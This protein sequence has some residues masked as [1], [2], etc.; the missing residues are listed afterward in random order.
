M[1]RGG[2]SFFCWG[3]PQPSLAASA[4]VVIMSQAALAQ[5]NPLSSASTSSAWNGFYVGANAGGT[6]PLNVGE[7]L[8]SVYAIRPAADLYPASRERP[9]VSFGIQ[10]GYNW[11][12]GDFVYGVETDINFLDGRGGK[13]QVELQPLQYNGRTAY[14][15]ELKYQTPATFFASLRGRMGVVLGDSLL[16]LTGGVA[17][18]GVRGPASLTIINPDRTHLLR[19]N[20]S[21]SKQI[22]YAFGLGLELPVSTDATAKI[23]T[24][25][26]SQ[27]YNNQTF[28]GEKRGSFSSRIL[29][30]NIVAR[31]GV[32]HQF[33][34]ANVIDRLGTKAN[35]EADGSEEMFS[36][37]GVTTTVVQG[38]PHFAAAYS[39]KNSFNPKGEIRSG[40]ISDLFLGVRLWDGAEAY[41]N[42][43]LIQGYG[44]QNTV[45]TA[46]YVNAL[47]TRVGSASPYL[48]M[49][50]YF[51]RQTIGLGG[52]EQKGLAETGAASEMLEST[53]DQ[54]ARRVDRD[55]LTL[56]VGKYSVQDIF[57]DNI[58][59]HDP[60][61]DFLN[62]A[63]TTLGA[64]DYAADAWGYS[65]GVTA[66]LKKDWWTLRSGIFQLSQ[67]PGRY[68]LDPI[69]FNQYMAV[70]EAEARYELAGQPGT[71][72]LLLF[73][74]N[75]NFAKFEEINDLA[76]GLDSFPPNL[77]WLRLRRQKNGFG[78]NLAQQ[79]WPGVGL[80]L[81]AGMNDGRYETDDYTDINRTI[82]GGL[83][84][85]GDLWDRKDDKIGVGA[86]IGAISSSFIR[87]LQLG[88]ISSFVGDGA[89]SYGNEKIVEAFYKCGVLDWLDAT[90]DY[91]F[92]GNPGFNTARGPANFFA[93]RLTAG[94]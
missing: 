4:F 67:I 80:F 54:I 66:E 51:V 55:R 84:F 47:T 60:T 17:S 59:A 72:K 78:V 35:S 34:A 76:F 73:S 62:F 36:V 14:G 44:P 27:G 91:Q 69:L 11:R 82:A 48:R 86:S 21:G 26:L 43:E 22:K 85:S 49:Q 56:T 8:R 92:V 87:Y 31:V 42:P 33:G 61:T 37:H 63:F 3:R 16:Y 38:Y 68:K 25:F 46:S 40:T 52:G 9:G 13:S 6:A 77:S 20:E 7:R 15:Y 57:D 70:G 32:N 65:F 1:I 12:I 45:G 10:A 93:L 50:R 71:L 53:A 81:R 19:A 29:N 28:E 94:F 2:A 83:V 5:D 18:G 88:G 79:I 24:L 89:L 23:E 74:D 64:F 41:V 90:L 39:G 75:G 30:E 58:Y